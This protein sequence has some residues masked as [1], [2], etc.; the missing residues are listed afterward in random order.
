MIVGPF[1]GVRLLVCL[2]LAYSGQLSTDPEFHVHETFGECEQ[3]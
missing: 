1:H 2:I 3:S